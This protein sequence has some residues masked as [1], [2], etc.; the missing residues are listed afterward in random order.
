MPVV[1]PVMNA[2]P[3]AGQGLL[4]LLR[5]LIWREWR[6]H[7]W[8]HGAALLAEWP[9]HAGGFGYEAA[10]LSVTLE[11]TANGRQAVVQGGADWLGRMP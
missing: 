3:A 7:P 1:R 6:H 5:L 9:D 11:S 4:P 8:R 10:C 2:T